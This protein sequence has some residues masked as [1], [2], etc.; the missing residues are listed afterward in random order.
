VV[1]YVLTMERDLSVFK[2]I[3]IGDCYVFINDDSLK[4]YAICSLKTLLL[5]YSSVK[6][7]VAVVIGGHTGLDIFL[8]KNE[9]KICWMMMKM[10]RI[11]MRHKTRPIRSISGRNLNQS[12]T[13]NQ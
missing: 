1:G 12:L 13:I 8:I 7:H 3:D 11:I 4:T 6:L 5:G 2:R 10:T 9:K